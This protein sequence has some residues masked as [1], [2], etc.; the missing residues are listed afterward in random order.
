MNHLEEDLDVY[1][2]R[3]Y[4]LSDLKIFTGLTDRTLR[5]YLAMG[6]LLGE[7]LNGIWHFSAKQV[8]EF[9]AHPSVRPSIVA[10][11]NALVYDFLLKKEDTENRC[12][13]VLDLPRKMRKIAIKY[14]CEKIN[15]GEFQNMQ[16]SLD[17]PMGKPTRI[18]L[19]GKTQQ[20]IRLVN[21]YYDMQEEC[22]L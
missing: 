3:N 17:S 22:V 8:N 11:N 7:K 10:K 18:I 19:K 15:Q 1:N 21:G 12:C 14:F 13:M 16:F 5:N 4:T 2:E 20:I 9:M 6:I